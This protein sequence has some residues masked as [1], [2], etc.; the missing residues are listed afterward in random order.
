MAADRLA[1]PLYVGGLVKSTRAI[2]NTIPVV[3]A[4][5]VTFMLVSPLSVV[6]WMTLMTGRRPSIFVSMA[7]RPLLSPAD[8]RSVVPVLGAY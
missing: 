4:A 7:E 2:L 5:V 1:L 3:R 8:R 6:A